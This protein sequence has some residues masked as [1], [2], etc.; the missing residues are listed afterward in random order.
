MDGSRYGMDGGDA[1]DEDDDLVDLNLYAA[2]KRAPKVASSLTFEVF[3]LLMYN[4]KPYY[5]FSLHQN[6]NNKTNRI[7][8]K[9]T[10]KNS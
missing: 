6:N 10:L 4:N 3:F 2:Q 7:S 1:L 9:K 8:T 5:Y